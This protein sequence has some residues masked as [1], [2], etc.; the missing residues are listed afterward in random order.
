[1]RIFFLLICFLLIVSGALAASFLYM[2]WG[3]QWVVRSAAREIL[4][5]GKLTW[6]DLKGNLLYGVEVSGVELRDVPYLLAESLLRVQGFSVRL[7]EF[8][9]EGLDINITNGRIFLRGDEGLFFNVRLHGRALG[10]NIYTRNFDLVSMRGVLAQFFDLPRFAGTLSDVDLYLGGTLDK[11]EVNGRFTAE[12]IT[13]N[14][15]I[16]RDVPARLQAVFARGKVHWDTNGKLFLD[17][18]FLTNDVVRIDLKPSCLKFNGPLSSPELDIDAFCKIARTQ[19]NIRVKGSRRD[20]EINLSSDPV[21]PR[22]QLLLML[23]TGKRWPGIENFS[24]RPQDNSAMA[25]NLADYFL[26]GGQR[27]RIIRAL[28]LSAISVNADNKKQG[29]TF[30][31]DVTDR[32]GVDYGVAIGATNQSQR[33]VIQVLEGEYRLTDKFMMGVQKEILP[34]RGTGATAPDPTPNDIPDDRVFLKYRSSF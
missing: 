16:L 33:G 22:G 7:T 30:S 17:G 20:P 19:I 24:G 29:L 13:W 1:M 21:Y 12:K 8:S 23:A 26:F 3:A 34:A 32:L 6:N 15:F 14:D 27:A 9:L 10:G 2:P 31:K 18:G 11:P 5:E 28:G 4:G 25:S